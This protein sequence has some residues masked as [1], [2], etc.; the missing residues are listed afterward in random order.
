MG[1]GN[2]II[3]V[4]GVEYPLY[5]GRQAIEESARR[6]EISITGNSVKFFADTV[7]AGMANHATKLD[8]PPLPYS[9]VY[10]IVEEFYEEEDSAEQFEAIDTCFK[11][12][13]YGRDFIEK[14]EELKKKWEA[15]TE[16]M[17]NKAQTN[18]GED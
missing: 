16:A 3:R 5:F 2:C 15:E 11:E 6:S 13:K 18:T 12:S 4:K 1:N 17:K 7:Y 8:V 14:I 9:E 10:D